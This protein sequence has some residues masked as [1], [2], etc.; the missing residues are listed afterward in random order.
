M[1]DFYLS[2]S[3]ILDSR[4]TDIACSLFNMNF[5]KYLR[6]EDNTVVSMFDYFIMYSIYPDCR[7]T[8]STFSFITRIIKLLLSTSLIAIDH[9]L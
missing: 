3:I 5:D 2:V 8:V 4:I 7:I 1:F 6:L 9:I